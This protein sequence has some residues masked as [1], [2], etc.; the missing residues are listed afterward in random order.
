MINLEQSLQVVTQAIEL[1][2][3]KGAFTLQESA[4]IFAALQTL[5]RECETP[6]PEAKEEKV[7]AKKAKAKA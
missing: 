2:N 4:T 1:A 5:T 7:P 6:Q 3:G